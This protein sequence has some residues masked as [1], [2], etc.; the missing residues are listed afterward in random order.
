MLSI[1]E[2]I[3][4][5]CN[6][7]K[8]IDELL[9]KNKN[10]PNRVMGYGSARIVY[11]L[12]NNKVLKVAHNDA[13]VAQNSVE[14]NCNL[15]ENYK[16]LI[17]NIYS[18]DIDNKWVEVETAIDAKISDFI[19]L[20]GVEHE[21]FRRYLSY[22][23]SKFRNERSPYKLEDSHI[24][25]LNN[26]IFVQNVVKFMERIDA[27]AGDFGALHSWGVV[28]RNG[29]KQLVLIDYGVTYD[30]YWTHYDNRKCFRPTKLL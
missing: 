27:M 7:A 1:N 22:C 14:I 25:K 15:L 18:Y 29:H 6:T 26:N 12:D 13:G 8:N 20:V 30:V 9:T 24:N 4:D 2:L 11:E 17:T 10:I 21:D 3:I 5:F 16:E 23:S 28:E 19:E